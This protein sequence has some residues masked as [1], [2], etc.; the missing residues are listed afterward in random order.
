[1]NKR[2]SNHKGIGE[3]KTV[4]SE[5]QST[6]YYVRAYYT[7]THSIYY[8]NVVSFSTIDNAVKTDG[9]L[10]VKATTSTYSGEYAPHN[11]VAIWIESGS[12]SF[13]KTLLTKAGVRKQYLTNWMKASGG[14][15]T[16]DATTGA[17]VNSHSSY[18]VS[19]NGKNASG[20]TVG[21]GSYNVCI[22]FT[23]SNGSGKFATFSFT[24][25]ISI[26]SQTPAA[27]SNISNVILTWT[28]VSK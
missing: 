22:E 27:K 25:G 15:T 2:I 16:T 11:V 24:K 14:N 18:T 5:L 20:T 3:F 1:M 23:E 6:L 17:T 12:G 7:N 21:D 9:T 4:I 19:W 26:N 8:G 10:T 28:P 13:V